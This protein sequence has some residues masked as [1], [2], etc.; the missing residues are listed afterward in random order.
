MRGGKMSRQITKTNYLGQSYPCIAFKFEDPR[1]AYEHMKY[2]VVEDYGCE[3]YGHYLYTWD[4][5]YRILA[6]CKNCRG[7]IL[8]QSSEFHSFTDSG[9]SYYTDWFPVSSPRE[10][11]EFNRKYDGFQIESEFN[12]RYLMMTNGSL[13][14]SR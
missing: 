3:A 1:E 8:V 4:D 13:G 9:D 14:W 10:A 11:D 2:E 7:Y 6:K 5:G 12:D